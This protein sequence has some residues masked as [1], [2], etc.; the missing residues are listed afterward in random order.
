MDSSSRPRSCPTKGRRFALLGRGL[1]GV[2]NRATGVLDPCKA[3][4]IALVDGLRPELVLINERESRRE[5]AR[6]GIPLIGTVI[7]VE[8][9]VSQ[10]LIELSAAFQRLLAT[11]FRID[12]RYLDD[13]LRRDAERRER[14][15]RHSDPQP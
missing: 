3:E 6:R 15:T 10:S 12:C 13:A 14:Q 9:A 11:N 7:I 2:S 4:A 5:A 1:G 8:K